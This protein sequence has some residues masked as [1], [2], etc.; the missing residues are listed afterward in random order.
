MQ[1]ITGRGEIVFKCTVCG[2]KTRVPSNRRGLDVLHN[3]TIT[4]GCRGKL[5]KVSQL[6]DINNTPTLTPAVSGILDWIPHNTVY[7][8]TQSTNSTTWDI[9]H[10]LQ[11]NPV[12]HAYVYIISDGEKILIPVEQPTTIMIDSNRIQ[13][14]FD[15]AQSG[16]AQLVT[17]SSSNTTNPQVV[18][19]TTSQVVNVQQSNDSGAITIG[20]LIPD[21]LISITIRYVI[22]GKPPVDIVYNNLDNTPSSSSPWSGLRLAIVDGK[23]YSIR[24]IDLI[25]HPNAIIH[26]LSGEI[27]PQGAA[28]Y[29]TALNTQT[30]S[31]GDV[32]MLGAKSPFGSTDLIYDRYVDFGKETSTSAKILYNYGKLFAKSDIIKTIYPHIIVV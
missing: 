20:T 5:K 14:I 19:N 15:T 10:N 2:R 13:L 7:T 6:K 18:D 11:G 1:Q 30:P 21:E 17:L 28:V 16:V 27:P 12:I 3:C 31:V 22:S 4:S 8:H 29:I 23:R 25:N 24:S 32:V 9:T 26:F